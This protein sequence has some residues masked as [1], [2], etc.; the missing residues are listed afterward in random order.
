MFR[1]AT[2][3]CETL[4][5]LAATVPAQP[6]PIRNGFYV[7]L[8]AYDD[9]RLYWPATHAISALGF[10]VARNAFREVRVFRSIEAAAT[11]AWD[12]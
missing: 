7:M 8:P 3:F 12:A 9:P 10:V 2:R 4:A 6:L 1:T 5:K 11:F